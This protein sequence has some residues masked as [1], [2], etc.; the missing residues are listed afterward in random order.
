MVHLR[1]RL[2]PEHRDTLAAAAW[3]EYIQGK[4]DRP[5]PEPDQNLTA[6]SPFGPASQF[7]REGDGA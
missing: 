7:G 6:R 5:P 2:G 4:K 3:I 1:R